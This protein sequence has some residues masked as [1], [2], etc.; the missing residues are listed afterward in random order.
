MNIILSFRTSPIDRAKVIQ[1]IEVLVV[2][3][4][5]TEEDPCR[6]IREYWSL[7][8]VLLSR[9]DDWKAADKAITHTERTGWEEEK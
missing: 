5:G 1:V 4:E 2:K 9:F 7:D 3:G 6:I 8:G